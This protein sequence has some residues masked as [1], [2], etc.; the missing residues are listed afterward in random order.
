MSQCKVYLLDDHKI[1]RDGI[2]SILSRNEVF[3]VV[4]ESGDPVK[5]IEDLGRIDL[6]ILILDISFP[7][8][9]GFQIIQKVKKL[10]PEIKILIL[11]MHNDAEYMQKSLTLGAGGYLAKDSDS[12]ELISALEAVRSGKTFFS[13]PTFH[14]ATKEAPPDILSQREIEILKLISGGL[15]SKQIASDLAISTRTVETHRLNIMKKLG[16]NNSAETIS[17]AVKLKIL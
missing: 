6:E 13:H 1:I 14:P 7:M 15:S 17:V 12:S 9:S 8:I 3:R 11:S 16:T 10:R 4:G 5:F 2:K